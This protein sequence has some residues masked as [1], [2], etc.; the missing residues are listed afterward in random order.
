MKLAHA[1]GYSIRA[2]TESTSDEVPLCEVILAGEGTGKVLQGAV[3]ETALRWHDYTL[4][5]VTDNVPFEDT[6][7]IYLLDRHLN[8]ADYARMYFIYATGI[9]S[10]ID[11]EEDDTVR[12]DFLGEKRWVLKLFSKKKFFIPVLSDTFGVHRPFSFFR[13]FQLSS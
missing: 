11:L 10:D 2:L 6:L 7:N 3:F 5:F 9:F 8:V 13:R 1:L 12:F 4:L